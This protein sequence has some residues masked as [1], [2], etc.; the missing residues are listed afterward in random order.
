MYEAG[1]DVNKGPRLL[2]NFKAKYGEED[3]VTNFFTGDHSRP[4][5]RI[6]HIDCQLKLNYSTVMSRVGAR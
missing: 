4:T 5:E 1:Y 3:R 6:K 2:E